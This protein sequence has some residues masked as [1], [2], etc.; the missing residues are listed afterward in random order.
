MLKYNFKLMMKAQSGSKIACKY[1][2]YI[3][4]EK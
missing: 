1:I 2:N 3:S 4:N